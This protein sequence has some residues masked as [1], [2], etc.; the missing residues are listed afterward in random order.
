MHKIVI[1]RC[2]RKILPVSLKIINQ[3]EN[4]DK[5]EIYFE[6]IKKKDIFNN[7]E[8]N[9]KSCLNKIKILKKCTSNLTQI[10][11]KIDKLVLDRCFSA[12]S[13]SHYIFFKFYNNKKVEKKIK[14]SLDDYCRK[15]YKGGR[16]EIFGNPKIN[17]VTKY[18]D[19]PGMYGLCMKEKFHNGKWEFT[20]KS[21]FKEVGFHTVTYKSNSHI[22][23]LPSYSSTNK[24][25][26]NNGVFTDTIWFEE[27]LYF[28]NNGGEVLDLHHSLIFEKY[29]EVFSDFVSYFNNIREEGGYYRI[30]GKLMINSF[31][32][33]LAL[34]KEDIFNYITFSETEFL[35]LSENLNVEKFYKINEV[36]VLLIIIDYKFNKLYKN[37]IFSQN[38]NRNVGYAAAITAKARIKLHKFFC[39]VKEDGGRVLYCDTDSIFAA[40]DKSR[41]EE[42]INNIK[43]ISIFKD[44]V[45]AS[46]KSYAL[47]KFNNE[48]IIKIKGISSKDL[49]FEMFKKSF[50]E[51]SELNFEN[52]NLMSKKD[53]FLEYKKKSKH[54]NFSNYDKREFSNDKKNTLPKYTNSQK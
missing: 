11:K 14:N 29:E 41:L 2:F 1:F 44:A 37:E 21:S 19:F 33:S 16:C 43:W 22:P 38:I 10:I 40:Y 15:A 27:L 32:G 54:V 46:P 47:K 49:S 12:P 23:V 45:F 18:F 36:F 31:Y 3:I 25:L 17:E 8:R 20:S 35:Y 24:L 6:I 5:S 7:K 28:I 30:F 39:Q 34:K 42:S 48:E 9:I 13:I 4:L 50:Y 53:L 51:D 26:F 52:Q